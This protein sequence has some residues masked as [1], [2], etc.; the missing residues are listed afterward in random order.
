MK[1]D[2]RVIEL[3]LTSAIIALET[4]FSAE[5]KLL[6]PIQREAPRREALGHF[7]LAARTLEDLCERTAK[8]LR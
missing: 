1:W 4:Y 6:P 5:N 3:E 8:G 2:R 7:G